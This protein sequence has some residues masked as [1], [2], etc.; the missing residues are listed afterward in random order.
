MQGV[1]RRICSILLLSITTISKLKQIVK[2]VDAYSQH[3]NAWYDLAD[4]DLKGC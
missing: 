4:A 2:G 1:S 3:F